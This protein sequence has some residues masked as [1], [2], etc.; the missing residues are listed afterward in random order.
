MFYLCSLG[1]NIAPEQHV[2]DGISQLVTQFAP[3]TFS[4]LIYTAPVDIT[5]AHDFV[6]GLFYFESNRLPEEIKT[7]FNHLEISH[8]RNRKDPESSLKDRVLDLDILLVSHNLNDLKLF[9]SL[10]DYLKPLQ[11]ELFSHQPLNENLRKFSCQVAS[12]QFGDR[13]ATIHC[14]PSPC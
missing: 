10:P 13:A 8:G 5:S 9:Q 4:S 2:P 12:L 7:Q 3:V 14:D 6:N 11:Q 1:S